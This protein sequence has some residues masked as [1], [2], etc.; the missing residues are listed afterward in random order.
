[1][2][3][4]VEEALNYIEE[5]NISIIDVRFVD[6]LGRWHHV[7]LT[8]ERAAC[9]FSEGIP[10]DSSSIPGFRGVNCGDMNLMPDIGSA[11]LDPFTEARTLVFICS[12]VEADTG[13]GIP[14]D[15][16]SVLFRAESLL[17]KKLGAESL[18]L[19]ELEFYLFDKASFKTTESFCFFQFENIEADSRENSYIH[20]PSGGYHSMSPSDKDF[21]LRSEIVLLAEKAGIPIR[22]H[23][24]EVGRF[25]QQEIEMLPS[26]PVKAA[27]SVMKLKYLIRMAALDRG[28]VAT[29]MPRPLYNEPGNGMHFHQYL[30]KDGGSLFWDEKGLYSHFSDIGKAYIAGVLEHS[31]SIVG[32]T[33]PTTNS[34]RR[35]V[36]GFEAPAKKFYGLANRSAA[37]RIPKY[38]DKPAC[39][40]FEFR[41]P[42]ATCNPYL[43]VAAQLL[44]GLDGIMKKLDPTALGYGPFDDN[45]DTWSESKKKSLKD[46]PATL[47]LALKALK[48]DRKYLTQDSVFSDSILNRHIEFASKNAEDV[49]KYPNPREMELYFDL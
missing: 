36:S 4:S 42:D 38:D 48:S 27:D 17:K 13:E 3:Y 6:L 30:T 7:S 10:F 14:E 22:Y 47:D 28:M 9:F 32:L 31:S 33:N 40:R 44:A 34:Y 19:P 12:V 11:F 49:A 18:W 21:D 26:P 1:M 25:G 46:I 20:P 37:I 45:I 23:H 2:F 8:S 15:P 43:A 41:P 24:H 29:F 39:K 35:L 5:D 16:R